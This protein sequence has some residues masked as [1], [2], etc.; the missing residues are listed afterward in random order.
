M[1]KLKQQLEAMLEE[2]VANAAARREQELSSLQIEHGLV[3]YGAGTLGRTALN[4]V[5]KLGLE[6]IG[7]VD[8]TPE[9]QGSTLDG[10]PIYSITKLAEVSSRV[11]IVVTIMN[12]R[13]P[14][15]HARRRIA[16]HTLAPVFSYVQ[17]SW[18]YPNAIPPYYQFDLPE[19]T[20][21]SGDKI[22]A[23]FAV[24]ADDRS[25]EEYVTQLRFRLHLNYD[26]LPNAHSGGYLDCDVL[27]DLPPDL[28]FVDCGAY[29][30]D[31]ICEFVMHRGASFSRIIAFE[32]DPN[33]FSRLKDSVGRQPPDVANKIELYPSA[34]GE[35]RG[36]SQFHSTGDMGASLSDFG[37]TTVAVSTLDDVLR[38]VETPILVKMDIE[39]AEQSALAGASDLIRRRR[40][41]LVIAA[42]HTPNDLWHIPLYLHGLFRD[43]SIFARARGTDGMDFFYYAVPR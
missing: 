31:S 15:V 1:T 43:Y 33:N 35:R 4:A 25:R 22:R 20:L 38:R 13:L 29:D 21:L 24:L 14:F 12:P 23:A 19:D 3:L 41:F 2:P 28:T 37:G 26:H 42:Y 36:P 39:G 30:G 16:A 6:P 9:K 11:A 5:R 7:F 40:P 8:D 18:K 34:V 17:L 32:P 10:A 27:P